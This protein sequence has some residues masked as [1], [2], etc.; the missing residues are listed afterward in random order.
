MRVRLLNTVLI[1]L[2][3]GK[4]E[5]DIYLDNRNNTIVLKLHQEV[6]K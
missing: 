6:N 1:N 5:F 3:K 4:N 2:E